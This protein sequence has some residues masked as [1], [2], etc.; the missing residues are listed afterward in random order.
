MNIEEGECGCH[1]IKCS[2][3]VSLIFLMGLLVSCTSSSEPEGGA[4]VP[5]T[6]FVPIAPAVEEPSSESP[7]EEAL[8]EVYIPRGELTVPVSQYISTKPAF[9]I[10]Y[11]QTWTVEENFYEQN[12]GGYGVRF[13]S[14][15][16]PMFVEIITLKFE[17]R[18]TLDWVTGT[19]EL[20]T[21]RNLGPDWKVTRS[22]TSI[23][24]PETYLI[25]ID[26]LLK[27]EGEVFSCHSSIIW[28][29]HSDILYYI[30]CTYFGPSPRQMR[31]L[32][33]GCPN[34]LFPDKQECERVRSGL[35]W[36]YLDYFY[37]MLN[38][39]KFME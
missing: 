5:L 27:R 26:G 2:V 4:P 21:Q 22:R 16:F 11:P 12:V 14:D 38:S 35:D 32:V 31:E 30:D 8:P 19:W 10:S 17:E 24:D 34:E 37:C 23:K 25:E 13:K 3:V 29:F 1:F 15:R 7:T 18:P 39:F 20:N 36:D 28:F 9:S 33:K 6:E